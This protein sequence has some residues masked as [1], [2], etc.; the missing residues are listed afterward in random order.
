MADDTTKD[1][2]ATF[3]ITGTSD[4]L[5][6]LEFHGHEAISSL[7]QFRI[8]FASEEGNLSAA[9][10]LK[11]PAL[12][13]ITGEQGPRYVH[14]IIASLEQRETARKFTMYH[15]VLVPSVWKLTQRRDCR[16]FQKTQDGEKNAKE[17]VSKVLK[18]VLSE[19]EFDFKLK[20]NQDPP[21]REY[22]V[23][24]RESDWAFV[25][26][27][28]EE[29][30]IFYYF[31]HSQTDHML[32]MRNDFQF[33]RQV[34]KQE[35]VGY[36]PPG[37]GIPGKEHITRFFY[38]EQ[39]RTEKATLQDFNFKKPSV[40]LKSERPKDKDTLLERYD[41][42][43]EYTTTDEGG[44][45]AQ[46][47]LEEQRAQS[48]EA[49]GDSDCVRMI[50]GY[51]FQ[52]T[53]HD[54]FG[55]SDGDKYTITWMRH[56]GN[57]HGDLE[58]GAAHPRIR[59]ENSFRC[60]PR[61]TVY[62]PPRVTPRP[63][64]R[65]TQ[66]AIVTGP[67]QEEIYT[68]E[69]GRVKVH[70]H[71]DRLGK[72]DENSSCWIR[73]SQIWAGQAWGA[74]LI[75]RV[76]HEVVVDFLEG[77]PDRPI[78]VGRVYHGE[79]MPPYTLSDEKTKSTLK[80]NSS[81]G[82]K[83][84]NELRFEDKKGKEEVFLHAQKDLNESVQHNMSTSVG[85]NQSISVGGS[86]SIHVQ[87]VQTI[88]V[89]GKNGELGKHGTLK[90]KGDITLEATNE[91]MIKCPK[92]LTLDVKGTKVTMTPGK[93][94]MTSGKGATI[95]LDGADV[96]FKATTVEMLASSS[97]TIDGTY[98]RLGGTAKADL[99]STGPTTISGTPVQVNGPGPYCGRVTELA[100]ATITTGA[101]L[102]LIGGASFP[103]EVRRLTDAEC[104]A[105]GLPHGTLLVGEHITIQ[106]GAGANSQFQNKVLRDLGI[107][108]STPSGMTRLQNVQN[109]PGHHNLS[110]REYNAAD[111]LAHGA[112]NSVSSSTAGDWAL[113]HDPAGNAVHGAGTDSTIA[114]NPDIQLGPAGHPE[115]ADST[116]FHE[117][118]H[119]EHYMNGEARNNEPR[120]NGWDSEEE[121]QT[122][123][124]G[125]NQPGGTTVSGT[126]T[127]PSENQYL[128]DRN[129]PYRRA[130]HDGT[131][132]NP[133][134]T[135]ITP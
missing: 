98:V 112:N 76:G 43:G 82:G 52:L 1:V 124:G 7:F 130:D 57:K 21:D 3:T 33:H 15:A 16:I 132:T 128:G 49:E 91:I 38:E 94:E 51:Y 10:I 13:T 12:L 30:G 99:M 2:Q 45:L 111:T 22:C 77:D 46:V 42:P 110:I 119:S 107:M 67:K 69:H 86:Q 120:G 97:L 96:N 89:E 5:Y 109:N 54:R 115:P 55:A 126:P 29:E 114:Y 25:S 56:G 122:I 75:P 133:D 63:E 70:F 9:S 129:Y 105:R 68:D 48:Q 31:T 14:G 27:L 23:Q 35:Q 58:A 26:R 88:T 19:S 93:V 53:D 8:D 95:T 59:Y 60:I 127:S 34:P 85:G 79:N 4:A 83:G 6:V 102:V 80:S 41:S 73:A 66:T 87:G 125:V 131:Y 134:G 92:K 39:I 18:G 78:I 47:R 17:I 90:V 28:L 103:Y 32:R 108:S 72:M 84:Y 113:G 74:M 71:W 106:P 37:H 36:H 117:M 101:A 50:P 135:P 65:G 121:Y 44:D 40:N 100:V 116:L 104:D 11:K 123:Q 62:R 64:V 118:G 20:G 81:I 24:Y 61:K